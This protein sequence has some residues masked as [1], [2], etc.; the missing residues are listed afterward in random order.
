M[1]G[2][3]TFYILLAS[4][5]LLSGCLPQVKETQCGDNEA[6]NSTLRT[7]VPVVGGPSSF[8][9]I[10]TFYPTAA[11]TRYKTDNTDVELSVTISN[12]YAQTYTVEWKRI[13]YNTEETLEATKSGNSSTY[14]FKPSTQ[15]SNLGSHIFAVKLK[16][17]TGAIVD[18]H[19]FEVIVTDTPKP[20][21]DTTTI[22]PPSYDATYTPITSAVEYKFT[23]LNNSAT[24]TGLGYRTEWK[25]YKSGVMI[26]SENDLFDNTDPSGKNN[27]SFDVDPSSLEVGY[28]ILTARVATSTGE[29][30]AEKQWAVTVKNP[31]HSKIISRNIYNSSS[32]PTFTT[33]TVSYNGIDYNSETSYNFIPST[34]TT[35]A[36]AGS[37]GDYCV[38]FA[39]STG[40]YTTDSDYIMV[41]YYLDGSTLIYTGFTTALSSVVC[42]SDASVAELNNL[43]FTNTS[44]TSSQSHTLVARVY[45]EATGT[46]Y[47]S[48][49]MNSGLGTYPITWNFLVKPQ[50]EKPTVTFGTSAPTCTTSTSTAKSGCSITSDTDFTVKILLSSDD[51]YTVAANE[52]KF[53]YSIRL[54][55]NGTKLKECTK[56]DA[57]SDGTTDTVGT[58]GYSCVLNIPG[59]NASGPINT[60]SYSYEIQAEISDTDSPLSPSG[61]T[62]QTLSWYFPLGG[63]TE[64]NTSPSISDWSVSGSVDEGSSMS[65]SA[66]ITDTERDNFSYTI[67]YCTNSS[68]TTNA[69]LKSGTIT[70]TNNTNPYTLSVSHSLSEDFLLNLINLDCDE[71]KRNETCDVEFFLTVTD[72]PDSAAP[73]SV[74]SEK[75]TSSIKNINP[76]P[77]LTVGNISPAPSVF[78]LLY[79]KIFVGFPLTISQTPSSSITDSSSVSNEKTFRYQWFSKINDGVMS[80]T[81]IEGATSHNLNWTPSL[82]EGSTY[83]LSLMLCIEDQPE[84]AVSVVNTTDST[85]SSANPW[86]LTVLNNISV[87]QNLS[88]GSSATELAMDSDSTGNEMAVWYETSSTFNSVTSSAAYVAMFGNDKR[89]HVKKVLVKDREAMDFFTD[90]EMISFN[91]LPSGTTYA[92]KDLSITGN[93]KELYIAYL[94]SRDG[95]PNSFYPQ[96]RRIDLSLTTTKSAPNI[97][98]GKF[99]FDYDGLGFLN[100]CTPSSECSSSATSGVSS[101]TFSPTAAIT[102]SITLITPYY[103]QSFNFGTYNGTDTICSTCSG[104][105]MA[106]NL[107]DIINNSTSVSLIGYSATASGATVTIYGARSGDYYDS[108]SGTISRVADRLGKIYISGSSWYLPFIDSSLGGSYNDKISFYYGSTGGD[109]ST[110]TPQIADALNTTD[111]SSLASASYFDNYFDGTNLWISL[112]KKSGGEGEVYK[113]NSSLSL[114]GSFEIFPDEALID[115]K[116]AASSSYVYVGA[117]KSVGENISLGIYDVNG[118]KEDE[119][120]ISN[121]DN[122]ESGSETS[123]FFNSDDLSDYKIIPYNSEARIFGISKGTTP[124]NYKLYLGR[125]REVSSTWTLSCGDCDPISEINK[126][127]SSFVKLGLTRIRNKATPSTNLNRLSSDGSVTS[128]GI[129]DVAFVSFGRIT[130]ADTDSCDPALSVFNIEGESISATTIYDD[131]S[132]GGLFRPPFVKN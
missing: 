64:N 124:S 17:S 57:G 115:I 125:L 32:S 46:E 63:V 48:T 29:V 102:G 60:T 26:D 88:E 45:D 31:D 87:I 103:Q 98:A 44:P 12:P 49:D 47:S 104:A 90:S 30:V 111:L 6:F 71:K 7:C 86:T 123:D 55:Q 96:V 33:T 14:E 116:V 37:Q 58:D 38:S 94:A 99:G 105:V 83:D 82:V 69:T 97:H 15:S 24:I 70:R 61:T 114:Q 119:F 21:I 85:C 89:I 120:L 68:C 77:V 73:L 84:S 130:D 74:T 1:V 110:N 91:A 129:R 80:W 76:L 75:E 10:D 43:I 9:S 16:D 23:I 11:Q 41:N 93:D 122:V 66:E 42:L 131:T 2:L 59:Y 53:N 118:V 127:V 126:N 51:F 50:N 8:L 22:S 34:V 54:Y 78:N 28:Y 81:K 13:F 4:F 112:I 109:L 62:S 20:I 56:T 107:R 95:A 36:A 128:Q 72:V 3:K 108:S 19:T 132:D 113:L 40:T 117:T 18:T 35:P 92:I 79:P 5:I 25:L 52:N 67:K 65:F 100:G 27:P 106:E 121:S 39:S 101:L